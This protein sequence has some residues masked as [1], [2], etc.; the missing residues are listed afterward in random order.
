MKYKVSNKDLAEFIIQNAGAK[1]FKE[2]VTKISK[3]IDLSETSVYNKLNDRSSFSASEIIEIYLHFG[4]S[5]DQLMSRKDKH[6]SF[7]PF[8]ADGLKYKP[9]NYTDYINN[10]I[11]YYSKIKQLEDVHGY[12]LANEVPLFHLLSFP[13][14]MYMK[15]YIWNKT[16][17]H[18]KD[19]PSEYT[20]QSIENDYELKQSLALLRE[21]YYSFQDTQI[22][23]LNML[24]NSI[25]QFQYLIDLGILT[26]KDE[27]GHLTREFN[28]LV[29]N[30]ESLTL[31][32]HKPKNIKG[33]Q[34]PCNIYIT[35]MNIGSE[36]ILVK[37]QNTS[38]LFQQID[39]PNYMRTNDPKMIENQYAFFENIKKI[40]THIT[41][42]REKERTKFFNKLKEKVS[43]IN[44]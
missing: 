17:W 44:N 14:L 7:V 8:F 15:L 33:I 43:N 34:N 2:L 22:W 32:G 42:T 20:F 29:S 18:I 10:I 28:E 41:M 30:L 31:C 21:L 16:N 37:T 39:V 26:N 6:N 24:D 13:H 19:L 38:F 36:V 12:F 27:I 4:I 5:V 23:N 1:N 35:D 40:S 25:T 11:M 3:I 9:R